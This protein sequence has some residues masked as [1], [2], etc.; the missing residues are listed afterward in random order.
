LPQVPVLRFCR[1]IQEA[2]DLKR[3]FKTLTPTLPLLK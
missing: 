2:F 3:R 1:T